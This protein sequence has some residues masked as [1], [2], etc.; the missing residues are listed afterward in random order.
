M[1]IHKTIHAWPHLIPFSWDDFGGKE[2]EGEND[3]LGFLF[4]GE[5]VRENWWGMSIFSLYPPKYNLPKSERK[6]ERKRGKKSLM[7]FG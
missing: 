1:K 5:N 7:C 3:I 4:E 2:M 6:W